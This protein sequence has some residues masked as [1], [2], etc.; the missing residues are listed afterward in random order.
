VQETDTPW[1]VLKNTAA[2]T[3]FVLNQWKTVAENSRSLGWTS[4]SEEAM[5]KLRREAATAD[6]MKAI[7]PKLM[8][9]AVM[10][11]AIEEKGKAPDGVGDIQ[12]LG[13][14][15]AVSVGS[16]SACALY[17]K[18]PDNAF[19]R[20]DNLVTNTAMPGQLETQR[21]VVQEVVKDAGESGVPEVRL[22]SAC[23]D[24]M[25]GTI[26]GTLE[27]LGFHEPEAG[28]EWCV[29]KKD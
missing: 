26:Y 24:E 10:D 7:I 9:R 8:Q 19:W 11:K 2:R 25:K 18:S 5:M 4:S 15:L 3:A 13:V 27:E 22:A 21:F 23:Y 6:A 29:H 17:H 16:G 1:K 20:I 14:T 28:A 12:H